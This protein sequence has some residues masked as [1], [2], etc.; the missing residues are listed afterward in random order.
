MKNDFPDWQDD[1]R[2]DGAVIVQRLPRSPGHSE[3]FMVQLWPGK[4]VVDCPCC[5]LPFKTKRAAK[6][7]IDGFWPLTPEQA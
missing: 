7:A 3:S 1:R 6:L 4:L 5:G 2:R